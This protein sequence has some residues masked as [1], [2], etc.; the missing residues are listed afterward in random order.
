MVLTTNQNGPT[1]MSSIVFI[2]IRHRMDGWMDGWK[3]LGAEVG[4]PW[5]KSCWPTKGNNKFCSFFF[6]YF[7][8]QKKVKSLDD[9]NTWNVML[10]SLEICTQTQA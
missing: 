5:D 7:F 2:A 3:N 1:L 6:Y 9:H 8:S 10:V 4:T